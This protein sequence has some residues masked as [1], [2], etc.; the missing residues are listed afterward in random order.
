MEESTTIVSTTAISQPSSH[1]TFVKLDAKAK[2]EP[3]SFAN[4]MITTPTLKRNVDAK[5]RIL[6]LK[7]LEFQ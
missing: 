2:S 1:D 3:F 5:P 4:S 6:S 7:F